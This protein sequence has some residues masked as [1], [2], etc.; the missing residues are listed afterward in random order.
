MKTKQLISRFGK[1]HFSLILYIETRCVDH[2][3]IVD[4]R[5][6]R[7]NPKNHALFS[8]EGGWD[9]KYSTRLAEGVEPVVGHDDWDCIDD[10]E[11]AGLLIWLG[12]G[13]NP[14]F[15]LTDKGWKLAHKLRRERAEQ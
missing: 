8:H 6:L 12:T 4:K 3:G 15:Q 2:S 14:G 7:C 10:L 5:H 1:D 13:V 11:R 9:D